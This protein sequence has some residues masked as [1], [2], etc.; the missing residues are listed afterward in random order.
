MNIISLLT[1]FIVSSS[2]YSLQFQDIDGQPVSMSQFQGKKVLLVNIATGSSKVNQ[3]EGLQQLQQQY[4]DSLVVIAFPSNSFG[5]EFRT[6]QE[7]KQFCQNNYGVTFLLA[8]KNPIAGPVNQ[9]VYNWLT[10]STENSVTNDPVRGDFQKY[11]ISESGNLIGIFSPSVQPMSSE[12]R[13]ALSI[14]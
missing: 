1:A 13:S 10:N 4:S 6:D 3:L 8:L 14:Q 12:L 11:L 9:P 2:I 5:K 7:I